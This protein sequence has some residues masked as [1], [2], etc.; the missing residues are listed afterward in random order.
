MDRHNETLL[1]KGKVWFYHFAIVTVDMIK[2]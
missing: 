2:P 1:P